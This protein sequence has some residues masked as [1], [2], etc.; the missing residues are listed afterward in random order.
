MVPPDKVFH[1][2]I[3]NL[4]KCGYIIIGLKL[5]FQGILYI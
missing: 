5:D 2:S 1:I 4:V 3:G